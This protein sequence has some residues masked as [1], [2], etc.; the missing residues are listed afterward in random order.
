MMMMGASD[1][2]R[3]GAIPMSPWWV[4]RWVGVALG[5]PERGQGGGGGLGVRLRQSLGLR[6]RGP[7]PGIPLGSKPWREQYLPWLWLR[8]DVRGGPGL[9]V[10]FTPEATERPVRSNPVRVGPSTGPAG[11]GETSPARVGSWVSRTPVDV[12]FPLGKSIPKAPGSESSVRRENAHKQ[13][14]PAEA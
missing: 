5:T 14:K 13:P 12:Q 2:A 7:Q 4:E 1:P 3:P 6:T 10:L 9:G 8:A 11:P